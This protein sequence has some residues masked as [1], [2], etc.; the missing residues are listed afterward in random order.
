MENNKNFP[1]AGTSLSSPIA[2]G[3]VALMRSAVPPP[4]T[5]L[6]E[7]GAYCRLVSRCLKETARLQVL[8]LVEPNEIVGQGLIDA[9]AAVQMIQRLINHEN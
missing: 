9:F 3:V 4:Q 1:A 6:E 7:Y 8:D 2:S 5:L